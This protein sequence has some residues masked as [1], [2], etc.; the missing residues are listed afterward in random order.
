MEFDDI[1]KAWM[2][3][4]EGVLEE[5]DIEWVVLSA[6]GQRWQTCK[7][8]C[9]GKDHVAM[10]PFLQEGRSSFPGDV[11]TC[12]VTRKQWLIRTA[13]IE[14]IIRN[15]EESFFKLMTRA[16]AIVRKIVKKRGWSD[17]TALFLKDTHGID[18]ALAEEILASSS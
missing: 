13:S 4:K 10:R 17:E 16:P 12:F 7:C 6:D 5:D 9:G 18:R 14:G 15:E 2:E 8:P 1:Y 3:A 11:L